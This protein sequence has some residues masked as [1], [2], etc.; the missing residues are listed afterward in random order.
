MHMYVLVCVLGWYVCEC[1]G[2]CVLG[3]YCVN[4]WVHMCVLGWYVCEC[5]PQVCV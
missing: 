1:V 5:V 3:W 4:V 2:M